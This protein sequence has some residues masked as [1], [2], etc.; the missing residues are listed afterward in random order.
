MYRR[1]LTIRK[2]EEAGERRYAR[3]EMV[4]SY[5]A[6]IG[7]EATYVGSAL[8]LEKSDYMTG[9]HRSHG[10]P[11][12]KGAKLGPLAAEVMAKQTGV[13]KGKGGS[14]HLADFSVGSLG[15]SGIVGGGIP[16]ALGSAL[17]SKLRGE[18]RV[19]MSYFGDGAANEGVFHECLNLAAVRK[20]PIVF[21]CENNLYQSST[22]YRDVT[23]VDNISIRAVAYD[24]PGVTVDGQ[25]VLEVYNACKQAVDRARAGL[26]PTLVEC[27][28][29]RYR[30]HSLRQAMPG[31]SPKGA[32]RS[33]W[34]IKQ[35]EKRDPLDILK[36]WIIANEMF[37]EATLAAVEKQTEVEAEEAWAFAE[38]SPPTEEEEIWTDTWIDPVPVSQRAKL[39]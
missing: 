33:E 28:T 7:Q 19:T 36:S 15:E 11:I 25:N 13:C 14:K 34:E 3:G 4:G 18:K 31:Q 1:M 26:G 9:T 8:A 10:H 20:M 30:E 32:Y 12:A 27:R 37:P 16:V 6:S 24:M 38:K 35:W 39:K 2:F 23:S 22:P 17:A 21:V 5:H 29:Y